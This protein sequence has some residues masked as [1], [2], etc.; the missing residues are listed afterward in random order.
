MSILQVNVNDIIVSHQLPEPARVIVVTPE[1][2]GLRIGAAGID[3]NQFYDRVFQPGEFTI[4]R[5]TFAADGERFR[6]AALAD[7]IQAAAQFDPHFAVGMSQVDP[8]P[9]QIDAVY[10]HMLKSPR[11]R[12]LLADDPG[13]GKTIMA[14]LLLKELQHRGVVERALVVAPANL[15]MQ[16]QDEMQM[17]F[18]E[19]F[20]VIRSEQLKAHP[21][22]AVWTHHPRAVISVDLAKRK[23]VTETFAG[24][25]WDLVVVDEAHKMAAYRY[26][27]KIDKTQAYQLGEQLSAQTDHLLL[28]TATPHR[29][30]P[31]NFRLLLMLLDPDLFQANE[32]LQRLLTQSDMPI[33]LRRL[34]EKMVDFENK[35]LFPPR[36]VETVRYTLVG[37]EK[38]LYDAVTE[39]VVERFQ[40][41]EMIAD[42]RTRRNVA[43]ALMVLQ[44]RLASSLR[45]IRTSLARRK[46]KLQQQLQE[47]QTNPT[48]IKQPTLVTINAFSALSLGDE[49]P[50]D[51]EERWAQEDQALGA[52]VSAQ[53]VREFQI[54]IDEVSRL[55]ELARAAEEEAEHHDSERKLAELRAVLKNPL[56]DGRTL[57]QS[58][59][60]LVVFTENR[61]T[62]DYLTDRFRAWGFRVANIY[63]GMDQETRRQ[64]QAYFKASDGAQIM[65]AT[66]AAGEGINLQFCRLMVN[67][68]IPWNPNR[69]EQRM[70]RIHRY[71]QRYSVRIFNLV[72]ENT[73]EGEVLDK[74]LTKLEQ[75]RSDLGSDNVYDIIGDLLSAADLAELVQ[76]AIKNRQTLEDIQL[77]VESKVDANEQR[78]RMQASLMESLAAD[79]MSAEALDEIYD[80]VRTAN[81]QRLVPE[82]IE[83][84]VVRSFR[85]LCGD[86]GY[87]SDIQQ[88]KQDPGVWTI[89][90]VPH[91]IRAAAPK[92]F[93][94]RPSYPQIIFSKSLQEQYSRAEFIAPGHPL[95][96]ALLLLVQGN[97]SSM[98]TEGARFAASTAEQGLFWL[99]EATVKDGTGAIAGQ[100]LIGVHQHL[101]GTLAEVDPLALL[102]A[103]PLAKVDDGADG[104]TLPPSIQSL[105]ST[106]KPVEA[107][108]KQ[109]V[110]DPYVAGLREQRQREGNV[111]ET[112]LQRSLQ[113]LIDVQDAKILSYAV[114]DKARKHDSHAYDI[115]LR[116]L[117][118]TLDEYKSRLQHRME[119]SA[120]LRAVGADAPRVVGVCAYVEAPTVLLGAEEDTDPNTETCAVEVAMAYERDHGREPASVEM[121][122]LGFDLRSRGANEIRYI[123]VKGRKGTG[124]VMLTANEWIKAARFGSEYWLYVVYDCATP[125]PRLVVIQDPAAKLT[126]A[127]NVFSAAR[128]RVNVGEINRVGTSVRNAL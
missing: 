79:V 33:F 48:A 128:F 67:Y 3:T 61:D 43:L 1:G 75:M 11:I 44:R 39:Y 89:E 91:F 111:R 49:E 119:E 83:Q 100:K 123:E 96:D 12:F 46:E 63:G 105:A 35:P 5:V 97:Y 54:E 115:G 107:W 50:D 108:C 6:L 30:D 59:E 101:D 51:E 8:L 117:Q 103:E 68:D 81:E 99:L 4:R 127:E 71:G 84:F 24:V 60:K 26:G 77:A 93:S 66:E 2:T 69:L 126:V 34:K 10:N 21:G 64:S 41:A 70:G 22:S 17:R 32:G 110:V 87:R 88:R 74:I 25:K 106:S 86:K 62:L 92:G 40:R 72:A 65:V 27:D 53:T 16:W 102:D 14:G 29:G 36:A 90:T 20:T 18:G 47:L 52:I 98:L 15:T 114:D 7:R 109:M 45:A 42:E 57:W 55:C 73:R 38:E 80:K 124:L 58:G 9:H 125:N 104:S 19:A 76:R 82:Y 78:R 56:D 112:Y 95:F 121:Q 23:E 118:Q 31:D 94:I 85:A 116:T 13:A 122:N 120:K 28:M 37:K 113:T